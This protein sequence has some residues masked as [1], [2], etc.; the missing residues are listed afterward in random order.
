[1]TEVKS[2]VRSPPPED[3]E[4]RSLIPRIAAAGRCVDRVVP[5][6][7][8]LEAHHGGHQRRRY[9][10]NEHGGSDCREPPLVQQGHMIPPHA[11]RLSGPAHPLGVDGL[12]ARHREQVARVRNADESA[13]DYFAGE[14]A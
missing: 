12:D 10:P 8:E 3:V 11:H 7:E 6:A 9:A 13:L 14:S 4:S 2:Y 5:N 1:M